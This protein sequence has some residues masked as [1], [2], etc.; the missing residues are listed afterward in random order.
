MKA[1]YWFI[2]DGS[3][4]RLLKNGEPT[5]TRY[6]SLAEAKADV[7]EKNAF[8]RKK[9]KSNPA[10]AADMLPLLQDWKHRGMIT[11]DEYDDSLREIQRGRGEARIEG[12]RRKIIKAII[13]RHARPSQLDE[14]LS[15]ADKGELTL[16]HNTVLQW[17]DGVGYDLFSGH[18]VEW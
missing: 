3:G 5:G 18:P 8:F 11:P 9:G 16:V 12:L 2:P 15:L 7:S 10:S 17:E 13:R 14:M 1:P 4:Y 6:A